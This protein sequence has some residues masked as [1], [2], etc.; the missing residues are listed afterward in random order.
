MGNPAEVFATGNFKTSLLKRCGVFL[1]RR[2]VALVLLLF[3]AVKL[4]LQGA[5]E[6]GKAVIHIDHR[7]NSS[8]CEQAENVAR[9]IQLL[10]DAV[11][12]AD[13]V[14][15]D[16]ELK[17]VL[18]FRK[19]L[20][21]TRREVFKQCLV[22]RHAKL[23]ATSFSRGK[24]ALRFLIGRL[25]QDRRKIRADCARDVEAIP[26][27][28]R[29]QVQQVHPTATPKF[30]HSQRPTLHVRRQEFQRLKVDVLV[31]SIEQRVDAGPRRSAGVLQ[32]CIGRSVFPEKCIILHR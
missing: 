30:Q 29:D 24:V 23:N 11:A 7:T 6:S 21:Q 13:C 2:Q 1:E 8:W 17:G 4:V 22:L 28:N 3:L 31:V 19:L 12:V 20:S 26:A 25:N 32:D 10:P 9:A 14:Y 15:P 18:Q 27:Q 5:A 16:D